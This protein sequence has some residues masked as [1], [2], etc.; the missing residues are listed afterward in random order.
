MS[1]K[2][3]HIHQQRCLAVLH[4][5]LLLSVTPCLSSL[6]K[7]GWYLQYLLESPWS[8]QTYTGHTEALEV[9]GSNRGRDTDGNEL[10][11]RQHKV[12]T[13][14]EGQWSMYGE[15]PPP[16]GW[17]GEDFRF[18]FQWLKSWQMVLHQ[19]SSSPGALSL[20]VAAK[21]S[22]GLCEYCWAW[23]PVPVFFPASELDPSAKCYLP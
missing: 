15:G 13:T 18:T 9:E 2:E 20:D 5:K 21:L 12:S 4:C 6:R 17:K 10:E 11:D 1:I 3:D 23:L 16:K 22:T 19:S 8:L 14:L 7:L